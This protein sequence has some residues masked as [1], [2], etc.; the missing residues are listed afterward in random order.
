MPNLGAWIESHE[1][2]LAVVGISSAV[3]FVGSL[4]ALPFVVARLPQ[5]FFLREGRGP[6]QGTHPTLRVVLRVLKNLLGVVL[7]LAGVAMLVL[8]GQGLLT[9][10]VGLGL[11]DFPGKRALELKI[12]RQRQVRSTIQW[13]RERM[14]R[15]PL[16]L[17]EEAAGE[18]D[19]PDQRADP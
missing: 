1:T 4:I 10:L 2:A 16:E 8:P 6:F 18:G 17:P 5:D 11:V 15:P 12:A 13:V 14:G 19:G 3:L 7:T 9:I